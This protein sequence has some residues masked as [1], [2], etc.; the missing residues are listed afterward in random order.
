MK[1]EREAQTIK[2]NI[3]T[4]GTPSTQKNQKNNN[5]N[6]KRQK[7]SINDKEKYQK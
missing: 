2:K 7:R 3:V 4:E 1:G 6:N 5:N